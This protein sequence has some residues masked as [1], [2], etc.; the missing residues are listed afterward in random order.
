MWVQ[1][2]RVFGKRL[3]GNVMSRRQAQEDQREL[4]R[5]RDECAAREVAVG[6]ALARVTG[7]L[8][9]LK[10]QGRRGEGTAEELRR[11]LE[12]AELA[13]VEVEVREMG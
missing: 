1:E 6:E 5:Q 3:F 2:R 8:E 13:R 9:R 4:S 10:V 12:D 11:D 7:E